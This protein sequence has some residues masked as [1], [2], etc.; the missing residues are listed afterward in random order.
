MNRTYLMMLKRYGL[1]SAIV[2]AFDKELHAI[3][4]NERPELERLVQK[5]MDG[6]DIAVSSLS[7]EEL[8]YVKT[9]RIL[10]GQTLY[11]DSWLEL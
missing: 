2:D 6:E 5:V 7:I 10:L 4:R 9:T 1:Y 11:S 8:Q 3:A